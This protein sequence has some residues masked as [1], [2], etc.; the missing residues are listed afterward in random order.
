MQLSLDNN[1][2]PFNLFRAEGK[3]G[4]PARVSMS[5][6]LRARE[7][8]NVKRVEDPVKYVDSVVSCMVKSGRLNKKKEKEVADIAREILAKCEES[9]SPPH[10]NP[11]VLSVAS[12]FHASWKAGERVGAKDFTEVMRVSQ[13]WIYEVDEKL[14]KIVGPRRS[15]PSHVV[16]WGPV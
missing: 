7:I 9:K 6:M 2:L 3:Y 12:V 15:E 8:T 5:D 10:S 1:N 14:E 13:M 16:R 4:K 11:L